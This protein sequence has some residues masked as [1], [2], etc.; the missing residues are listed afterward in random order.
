MEQTSPNTHATKD[1]KGKYVIGESSRNAKGSQYFKCQGY[2]H[3]VAHCPSRNLLVREA[4]D[5]EIKIIVYEPTGSATDFDD[6]VRISSIHFGVV[7]CAHTTVR[8]EN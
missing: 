5:N 4:D 2:D 1:P 7:R 3:V 6:D 8:D